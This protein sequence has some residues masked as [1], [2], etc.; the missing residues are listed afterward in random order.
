MGR[1]NSYV[2]STKA[3]KTDAIPICKRLLNAHYA[4]LEDRYDRNGEKK[5][6]GGGEEGRRGGEEKGR[7]GEREEGRTLWNK[8][9]LGED[10]A[11]NMM[12]LETDTGKIL[13]LDDQELSTFIQIPILAL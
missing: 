1:I 12:A 7:R 9:R 13:M 5:P 6:T 10:L 3:D 4:R 11:E 8:G 2:G